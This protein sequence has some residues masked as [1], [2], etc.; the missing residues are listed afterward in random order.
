LGVLLR[1]LRAESARHEHPG[2]AIAFGHEARERVL[3]EHVVD[4]GVDVAA[5]DPP[6]ENPA[7]RG[8][9]LR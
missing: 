9:R 8:S 2:D 7:D 6:L 5:V 3:G 1:A 4:G